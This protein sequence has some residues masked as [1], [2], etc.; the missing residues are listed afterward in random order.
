MEPIEF[1]LKNKIIL[2]TGGASGIGLSLTKQCLELGAR[3][4][5]ADLHSSSALESASNSNVLFVQSDVTRWS[6]F[7]KI[8]EACEQKWN[9]VPDAYG[10]CA[11]LF[12][13][14]FSNFWQDPEQDVGYKQVDV[15]VDHPIKLTRLAIKKSLGRGKRASVCIISSIAGISGNIAAP[16]YCATKHAIVGFVKSMTTS[17]T[18]TGVKVTAI[19]PGLV[20]TPLIDKQ[21]V[22]QFSFKE[23]ASLTPDEV[24][25]HMVPLIQE[26][27]YGCGTILEISKAGPRVIPPWNIDPPAGT[28]TG[29]KKEEVEAG[30]KALLSP[31]LRK[32]EAEKL[33]PKL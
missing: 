2:I 15:N 19:C 6:D 10:I 32:L 30:A 21:K 20:N 8:F 27:K 18:F 26:K 12:E 7:A 23:D 4:L 29:L 3:V 5:V 25:T 22:E 1:P 13:P 33:S 24:A 28:G 16:L 31:I 11:G 17:E 9:D 14:P